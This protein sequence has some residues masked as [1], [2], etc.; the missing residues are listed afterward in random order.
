MTGVKRMRVP[1]LARAARFFS[2]ERAMVQ[3]GSV[4]TWL[5]VVVVC[6]GWYLLRWWRSSSSSLSSSNNFS[7]S[8]MFK[9]EV[10]EIRDVLVGIS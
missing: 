1:E 6:L 10:M 9:T 4:I 7:S 5:G 3:R 2:E 8:S